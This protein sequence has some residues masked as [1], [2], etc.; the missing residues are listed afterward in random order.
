MSLSGTLSRLALLVGLGYLGFYVYGLIMGVF[1]PLELW[2]FTI[3]AIVFAAAFI[4]HTIRLRRLMRT[5]GGH[6][7]MM[8]DAH[9]YRER[10]GF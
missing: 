6:E 2:G 1:S 5:P 4:V 9:V 8:R 10:R 3:L 7:A